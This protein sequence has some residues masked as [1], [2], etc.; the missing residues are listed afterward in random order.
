MSE[1]TRANKGDQEQDLRTIIARLRDLQR[2]CR[3]VGSRN[4]EA[5]EME[6]R[7][8]QALQQL[9]RDA[10][11]EPIPFRALAR[12]LWA[13]ER[14]FSSSGFLS[15]AK[16]VAHVE[17]ALE[18]LSPDD[19]PGESIR[20]AQADDASLVHVPTEDERDLEI[21]STEP[22]RWAVPKPLAV[23]LTVFIVAVIVCAVVIYRNQHSPV[24]SAVTA[25][26]PIV[27]VVTA[28]PTPAPALSSRGSTAVPTPA[29][30]AILASEIGH[31]RLAL[32]EGNIDDAIDHLSRA[33]LIDPDHATVLGTASQL[34]ELLVKRADAAAD[35]GLW[36]VAKLTLARADRIATR[37]GLDHQLIQ[38]TADRHARMD[39]YQLIQ[40]DDL[41][42]IRTASGR[43]VSVHLKDGEVRES[44][45]KGT[46]GRHLLLDEDTEVRGGAVFYTEKIPLGDIDFLKV[47][48]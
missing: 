29:P 34:M 17:R 25:P 37:F 11:D 43:R 16:E 26:A 4:P 1:E 5:D 48:E 23:T 10:N 36:Q 46:D 18:A 45:I 2:K 9:T 38:D 42:A 8:S 13:V 24:Q 41:E 22:S 33:A 21:E 44:V 28:T 12:D 30:G 6:Q 19:D 47:W 35:G 27:Q 32:A 7:L 15:V 14:F 3:S 39:R 40:P 20:H 31:A